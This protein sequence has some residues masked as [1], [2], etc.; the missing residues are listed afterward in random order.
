M[1]SPTTCTYRVSIHTPV[2]G[3]TAVGGLLGG[4]FSGFNPHAR[5]GRDAPAGL[6]VPSPVSFNPHA[7][8]GRDVRRHY[9]DL[10]PAVFQ[11]TR[12]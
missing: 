5:E 4:A 2:K 6:F 12:P 11:S 7:R 8:E 1:R 3:V 9:W 10:L